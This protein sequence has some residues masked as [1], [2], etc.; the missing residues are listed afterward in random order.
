MPLN[1]PLTST[2]HKLFWTLQDK[3]NVNEAKRVEINGYFHCLNVSPY[4]RI[5]DS[6]QKTVGSTHEVYTSQI[7]VH[8]KIRFIHIYFRFR[9]S[10]TEL[11]RI[12]K[13]LRIFLKS[14]KH[15]F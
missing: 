9:P 6:G 8:V 4:K 12:M 7:H 10:L 3:K 2:A 5:K 1:M 14:F 11:L 13:I 15:Y